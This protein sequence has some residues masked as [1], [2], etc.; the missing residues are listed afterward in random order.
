MIFIS[1]LLV[2]FNAL[3]ARTIVTQWMYMPKFYDSPTGYH[4]FRLF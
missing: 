3:S 1:L 4:D 2:L